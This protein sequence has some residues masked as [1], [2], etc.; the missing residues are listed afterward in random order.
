VDVDLE[1]ATHLG[2]RV[3][4]GAE[5]ERGDEPEEPEEPEEDPT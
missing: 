5:G 4:R 1:D 3:R 2:L